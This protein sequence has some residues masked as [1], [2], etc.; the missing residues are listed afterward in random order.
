[1]TESAQDPRLPLF[2][3]GTL[4]RGQRNH[5]LL[6][7]RYV[8]MRPARLHGFARTEPLMIRSRPE[9]SVAGELYFIRP[10]AYEATLRDCDELEGIPP[11]RT[12]GRDYC[13]WRVTVETPEGPMDAWAYVHA[14]A[15]T[16][17]R[18][19]SADEAVADSA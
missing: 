17:R 6:A 11:G 9:A 4:R 15:A 12:V 8:R 19:R 16:A 7:R 10:D 14:S 18:E 13:R 5:H 1:M 3:F 2:V